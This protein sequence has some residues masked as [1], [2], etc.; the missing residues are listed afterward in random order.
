MSEFQYDVP[1]Y[2]TWNV[3]FSKYIEMV[4]FHFVLL[5]TKINRFEPIAVI[6]RYNK[7]CQKVLTKK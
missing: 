5:E 1:L 7:E 6:S 4:V 2:V 3:R